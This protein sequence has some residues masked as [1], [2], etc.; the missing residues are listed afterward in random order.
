M[1]KTYTNDTKKRKT[2]QKKAEFL[3]ALEKN[4]GNVTLSA[5]ACGIDR[6]SVYR[7]KNE[8]ADFAAAVA[9][10]DEV[11]I[12]FVES[13]LMKQ[14]SDNDT[15]AIIFYLKTR[16]KKRGYVEKQQVEAVGRTQIQVQVSNDKTAQ[17]LNDILNED[18]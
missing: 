18:H 6:T 10:I 4:L 3:A 1:G 17:Q 12:D 11:A 8:D 7:W 16:G 9:A 5:R 13:K 2:A 15:V 14:I